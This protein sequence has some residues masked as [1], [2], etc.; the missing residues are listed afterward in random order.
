MWSDLSPGEISRIVQ[1]SFGRPP[2]PYLYDEQ[3]QLRAMRIARAQGLF[4]RIQRGLAVDEPIPVLRYSGFRDYGRTGNRTRY[5]ALVH[6]RA[7]QIDLAAMG[8]Y[9]GAGSAGYLEDLLWTECESTW[10]TMPAHESH[11]GPID[12]RDAQCGFRYAMICKL[13]SNRISR[14]VHQRVVAEVRR[15][16]LEEYLNP[17]R[18]YWSQNFTNNWNAVCNGCVGLAAMLVEPDAGRLGTIL[19]RVLCGLPAFVSGFTEDGGCTEGPSY[20][21]YGFQWYVRF[22]AAL[23]EFTGGRIDLMEGEKIERIC[24]YPLAVTIRPA[25]E[26]TF[27]DCHSGYLGASL[28]VEIN[29]FHDVPELFGLCRLAEDRTLAV[30]SL[31]DLLLADETQHEPLADRRDRYLSDLAVAKA[32]FGPLTVGAKAGHN[33]E[34]HNHN[35]VGSFLVHRGSTFFLTD[36]GAPV[37]SRKTFSPQRYESIFCNSFGHSVPVVEGRGQSA[38]GRFAGSMQVE[39]LGD[40]GAKTLR[41]E[42]AGAYDLPSLERLTRVIEVPAGGGEVRLADAFAFRD[43]PASVAEAFITTQPAEVA[44]DGKSVTICSEADGSAELRAVQTEGT[45]DV[46]ELKAESQAEARSGEL[47]RRISFVPARLAREMTLRFALRLD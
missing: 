16:V 31:D 21:R 17:Q 26:L 20:W 2:M 3:V 1:E 10:W 29:R 47:V 36:L 33:Q 19:S 37:Y 22:A 46:A 34:H 35:D 15:R 40:D 9:L 27:A 14:E 12:L 42:M 7:A 44:P 32:C 4:D 23:H 38:G 11:A 13:L 18:Y 8:V 43:P 25:Q 5:E 24:R 30:G 6:R 45:F 28:A 41:I 39:G